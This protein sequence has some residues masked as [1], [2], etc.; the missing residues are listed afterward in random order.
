M[1]KKRLVGPQVNQ[2]QKNMQALSS[3]AGIMASNVG[4]KKSGVQSPLGNQP[5]GSAAP[6]INLN[7]V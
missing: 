6:I 7:N 4:A 5:Q 1:E 3:K 2:A